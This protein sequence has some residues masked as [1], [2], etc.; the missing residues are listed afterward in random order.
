MSSEKPEVESAGEEEQIEPTDLGNAIG[1]AILGGE[2]EDSQSGK[3][4]TEIAPIPIKKKATKKRKQD[5]PPQEEIEAALDLLLHGVPPEDFDPVT[6]KCCIAELNK[7]KKNAVEEKNYLEAEEY[8]QLVKKAQ[9]AADVSNFSSHCTNKLTYYMEK[10]ADAQDKVD[11][12]NARWD[13]TFQEFEQMVEQKMQDLTDQQTKELREFDENIPEELP[14]KYN[15]HSTEYVLLR[16]RERLLIKNEEYVVADAVRQKADVLEREELTDQHAKL[17]DDLMRERNA[18][19]EKH[20][21]QYDAFA[22]WLNGRRNQMV[23][24]RKKDLEGPTRRLE[25]YTMLVEKIE[26]KGLPPNPNQGFT[27]NRVSRKESIRAVRTAAQTPLDRDPA[28]SRPKEK[29][30]IPGFRPPS[31]MN[32]TGGSRV[33]QKA[34]SGNTSQMSN[35]SSQRV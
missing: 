14:P 9:K 22:T 26:K 32:R 17:Q 34:K 23:I 18:I 29:T 1:E 10:Q 19:I 20:S 13:D 24:E 27:T 3:R 8:A 21:K 31:A 33:S 16:K 30:I 2:E 28:K 5:Q 35:R 11:E 6:L 15:K 25:H 12:A 4:P 7:L